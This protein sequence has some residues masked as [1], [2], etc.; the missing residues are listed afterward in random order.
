[1]LKDFRKS[2][3]GA[4]KKLKKIRV[5]LLQQIEA[6]QELFVSYLGLVD[7]AKTVNERRAELYHWFGVGVDC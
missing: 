1:M 5:M 2:R 4:K 6:E 3:Y 7:L